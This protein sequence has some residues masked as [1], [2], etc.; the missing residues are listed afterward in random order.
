MDEKMTFL[1]LSCD[2]FSDLWNGHVKLLDEM[3]PDRKCKTIIVTDT[4]INNYCFDDV[5]VFCSGKEKEWS[6]RLSE[7]VNMVTT[8][9]ILITLDDYFLIRPVSNKKIEYLLDVM[10]HNELDYLRLYKRPKR[11]T[12]QRIAN[13]KNIYRVDT[14]IMYSVN[15]YTAFWN[16]NFLLHTLRA[17][18]NAW[19]FEVKLSNIASEYCAKC[20]VDVCNDFYILDVVRKGKLL[21]KSRKYFNKHPDLYNGNREVQPL[22]YE[23]KLSIKTFVGRHFPLFL[24]KFIKKIMRKFGHK[25]V[26]DEN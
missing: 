6:Q 23:I 12:K 26:S 5:E 7:A 15:L 14:K 4:N 13:C 11:A 3:W 24:Q 21:R 25:F 18:M 9:K 1:I 20:A 17:P 22:S 8:E 19:K 2:K 16:R 10:E